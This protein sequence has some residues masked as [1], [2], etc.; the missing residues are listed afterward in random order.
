[1]NTLSFG[2]YTTVLRSMRTMMAFPDFRLPV[3]YRDLSL[4][5]CFDAVLKAL[6]CAFT[7]VSQP[8]YWRHS[9]HIYCIFSNV[10]FSLI[11]GQ[12]P[13][14]A[15]L[16]TTTDVKNVKLESRLM[17]Q[18]HRGPAHTGGYFVQFS[19]TFPRTSSVPSGLSAG[20]RKFSSIFGR[21]G[22]GKGRREMSRLKLTHWSLCA[23]ME[24][25]RC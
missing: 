7:F 19:F 4:A 18:R 9:E 10:Y 11:L 20:S 24:S 23:S 3:S 5:T 17:L 12:A 2:E 21:F 8:E 14:T 16:E 22:F 13:I 6:V 15:N 25:S 1:M